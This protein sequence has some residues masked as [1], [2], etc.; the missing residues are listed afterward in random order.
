MS[1]VESSA[2]LTSDLSVALL[3]KAY[4]WMRLTRAF[5]E[6]ADAVFKQGKIVGGRFSQLGHEAISVGAA[7]A[8]GPSDILAPLHRDLGAMFVRGLT[9]RRMMAQLLGRVDGPSKGRDANMH[10]VGDLSL[11]IVGY[12][13]MLPASMPVAAGIAMAFQLKNEPRVAMTFFGDGSSS[14][15]LCHE[16]L[17]WAGVFKSPIVFICENN[18]Y[19]YSTPTS[20]QYAINDLADRA[21]GYGFPGIVVDGNDLVAVYTAAHQAVERARAGGGP[22]L[23]ECK[24][25]RMK[26]HAIHDNQAY[27]P[28][29]LIAEWMQKDPLLRFEATLREQGLLDDERKQQIEREIAAT[30]DD[31]LTFA[32]NS[33]FPDGSTVTEGV[34]A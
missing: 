29:E 14:E 21:A 16:T 6:R 5:D 25:F 2:T 18:Q 26:G 17:N 24:T 10:G 31:A 12:V 23:I 4:Y 11:G 9:P 20:R 13:S 34:Y 33:P 22:T 19:A 7:L 15:G 27:V 30:L 28:K 32:E 8:L 1:Q 3:E